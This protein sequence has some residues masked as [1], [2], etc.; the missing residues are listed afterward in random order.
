MH[1]PPAI[2][3]GTTDAQ[4]SRRV[5][6]ALEDEQLTALVHQ[7]GPRNWDFISGSLKGRTA[8]Q[9]RDR[10]KIYL[11]PTVN[12][13]PWTAEED[14]LLFE[15]A[16]GLGRKSTVICQY[17]E[18]RTS[19]NVKNRW[20][21]IM[22]KMRSLKM[23]ETSEK[24]FL[25]CARLITRQPMPGQT[26]ARDPPPISPAAFSFDSLL[27]HHPEQTAQR[28]LFAGPDDLAQIG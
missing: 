4:K 2:V 26:P 21:S 28:G 17:F 5:F 25:H 14:R 12:R 22:R 24:D 18:N 23:D 16:R 9:C 8:R 10:W 7:F 27:N 19:S 3:C 1:T 6:T 11:A 20:N 15:K 13:T